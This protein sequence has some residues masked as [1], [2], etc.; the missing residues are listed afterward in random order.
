MATIHL[1]E[2]AV[3]KLKAPDPSGRQTLHWDDGLKGFGVL[4]SG[5][6]SG[7]SYVA[8]RTLKC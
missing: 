4:V 6:T 3:G 8:Q 7:K 5:T 1:T 2:G